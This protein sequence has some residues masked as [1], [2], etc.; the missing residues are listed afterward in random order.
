[1][2]EI[3]FLLNRYTPRDINLNSETYTYKRAANQ[4]FT[5]STHIIEPG[6]F[7]E[8]DVS[9]LTFTLQLTKQV[10]MLWRFFFQLLN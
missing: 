8:E 3:F 10:D 5:Q 1:M 7:S 6:K 2:T 4:V 9:M